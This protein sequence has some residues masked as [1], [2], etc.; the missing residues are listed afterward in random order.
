MQGLILINLQKFIWTRSFEALFT[1]KIKLFSDQRK[2]QE[3]LLV[4][5]LAHENLDGLGE[6]YPKGKRPN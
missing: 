2:D 3:K 6:F 5:M 1:N 4:K